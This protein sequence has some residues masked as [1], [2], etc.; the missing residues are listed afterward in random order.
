L[1][2]VAPLVAAI[3]KAALVLFVLRRRGFEV[4]ACEIIEQDVEADTEPGLHGCNAFGRYRMN[5][6]CQRPVR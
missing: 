1:H 2:A 4:G 3:A 6:S 5:R